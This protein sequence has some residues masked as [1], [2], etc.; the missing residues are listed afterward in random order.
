MTMVR[1][2]ITSLGN[3]VSRYVCFCDEAYQYVMRYLFGETV[4]A[5]AEIKAPKE[6][7]RYFCNG[8]YKK[9]ELGPHVSHWIFFRSGVE[10]EWA[11]GSYRVIEAIKSGKNREQLLEMMRIAYV[12][13]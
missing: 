4:V 6:I 7:I 12:L 5:E 11:G 3:E 10:D 1:V 8:K 2:V 13:S 9:W